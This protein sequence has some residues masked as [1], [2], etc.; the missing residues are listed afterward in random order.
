MSDVTEIP[1]TCMLGDDA[2]RCVEVTVA[3]EGVQSRMCS[4]G[5]GEK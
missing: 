1:P 4:V 3:C 5:D 2:M